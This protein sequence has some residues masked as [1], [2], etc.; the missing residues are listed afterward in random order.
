LEGEVADDVTVE[1]EEETVGV[2]GAQDVLCEFEWSCG[3]EGLFFLGVG[4]FDV[5][6]GLEGLEGGF[7]VVGLVVDGDDNF[8]NSDLGKGLNYFKMYS[9]LVLYHGQVGEGEG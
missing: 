8:D 9:D 5:V 6:F 4:E 7:D 2:V 3:A 1:D